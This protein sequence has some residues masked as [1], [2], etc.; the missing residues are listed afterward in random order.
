MVGTLEE[1]LLVI[2]YT[3]VLPVLD[4]SYVVAMVSV[5]PDMYEDTRQTV[6]GGRALVVG[7]HV[8]GAG[9]LYGRVYLP[10]PAEL[11]VVL[12]PARVKR[13]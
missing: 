11:K 8:Q 6:L 4:T 1:I 9:E 13:R 10:L 3:I 5:R 12:E 2:F 7:R